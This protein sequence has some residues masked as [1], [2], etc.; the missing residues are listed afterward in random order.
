[1]FIF[2]LVRAKNVFF[3]INFLIS[4]LVTYLKI[5]K[6]IFFLILSFYFLFTIVMK[7]LISCKEN[8]NFCIEVLDELDDL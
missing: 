6:L 7:V 3:F 2:E 1:M 4:K 8:P 5:F